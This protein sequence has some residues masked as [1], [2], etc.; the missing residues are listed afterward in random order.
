MVHMKNQAPLEGITIIDC[1]TMVAGPL[2]TQILADQGAEVIKIEP[3]GGDLARMIGPIFEPGIS[4]TY[5]HLGRNKRSMVLDLSHAK[6]QAIVHKL[7]RT[8]DVFICNSRPGVMASHQ[9]DF[10]T[11]KGINHK[12]VYASITGFGENGPMS[13][14]RAYDPIIQAQTGI[15]RMGKPPKPELQPQLICDKLT[16]VYTAQAVSAALVKAARQGLGDKIDISLLSATLAFLATDVYWPIAS[17]S[18]DL[19]ITDT[20]VIYQA[21]Q[22][23][24]K[25]IVLIVMSDK[26]F[27]S[28]CEMFSLGNLIKQSHFSNVI[29][30]LKNWPQIR[31]LLA[32]KIANLSSEVA[33]D[34]LWQANIPAGPVNDI[35]DLHNDAQ[36]QATQAF[37]TVKHPSAGDYLEVASA[38]RFSHRKNTHKAPAHAGQH[39]QEILKDLEYSDKDINQLFLEKIIY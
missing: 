31:E 9:L 3:I 7:V 21:W 10:D 32:P 27:I 17:P 2:A 18:R 12:L 19:D 14:Q 13:D 26:E 5:I 34:K 36:I 29:E 8:A 1:T 25:F 4:G 30:R 16:G 39:S 23:Q 37:K 38:A 6:A 11:L 33:L 20:S 35:E 28:L 24:D 15:A 22:T